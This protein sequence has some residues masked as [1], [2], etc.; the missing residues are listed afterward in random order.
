MKYD[1]NHWDKTEMTR[2]EALDWF[3][4]EFEVT[5][6]KRCSPTCPQCQAEEWAIRALSARWHAYPDEKPPES[7]VYLVSEYSCLTKK[8]SFVWIGYWDDEKWYFAEN[9]VDPDSFD[10]GKW[11]YAW[12]ELPE[13]MARE[14]KDG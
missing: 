13:P 14:E 3:E 10:I 2:E 12:M 11:I 9:F 5:D 6:G 1:F 4:S 7:G 8:V